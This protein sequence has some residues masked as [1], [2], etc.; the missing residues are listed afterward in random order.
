MN[1]RIRKYHKTTEQQIVEGIFKG[2]WWLISWPFRLLLGKRKGAGVNY[3]SA[4]FDKSFL[5]DKWQEIEEL[6]RLGHPSNFSRAILEADKLLDHVLKA[7]R[8]PGMT[9]G[10]RLK[11]SRNRFSPDAY[12]A[13]WHAHKVR[14]EIVHNSA[15]QITDF[16][17]KEAIS[18]FKKALG[19]LT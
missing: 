8:T 5:A 16:I 13:A 3:Q 19:E 7:L 17:A 4:S 9:M 6:M 1:Y 10:D 12:E 18:N 14:N 2:L 11:A 15:Y